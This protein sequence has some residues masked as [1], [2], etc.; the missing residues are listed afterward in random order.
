MRRRHLGLGRARAAASSGELVVTVARQR[1]GMRRRTPSALSRLITK[2]TGFS[3]PRRPLTKKIVSI[4]GGRCHRERPAA[5]T[6]SIT[7]PWSGTGRRFPS[8]PWSR[9]RAGSSFDGERPKRKPEISWSGRLRDGHR[10]KTEA[11]TPP[12]P[13]ARRGPHARCGHGASSCW[14]SARQ[15]PAPRDP[16]TEHGTIDSA[17][18]AMRKGARLLNKPPE[19][20]VC[21][22]CGDVARS[23]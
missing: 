20:R 15:R 18:D 2:D 7:C 16:D 10:S 11:T 17:V 23:T 8:G 1:H 21:W 12:P 14:P 22:C 19:G 4:M 9:E 5:T 3:P 13:R 6:A